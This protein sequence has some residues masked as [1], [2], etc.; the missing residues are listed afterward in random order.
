L[1]GQI[2]AAPDFAAIGLRL[3]GA[4]WV[5]LMLHSN[6]AQSLHS[7]PLRPMRARRKEAC[8]GARSAAPVLAPL[9]LP[10]ALCPAPIEHAPL[11]IAYPASLLQPPEGHAPSGF[12]STQFVIEEK[13]NENLPGK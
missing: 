13:A 7:P 1:A 4:G 5:D 12:V 10:A 11:H 3:Y 9:S 8:F 6:G 2:G